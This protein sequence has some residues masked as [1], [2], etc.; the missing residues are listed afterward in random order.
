ML[1]RFREANGP[2]L[3]PAW[4]DGDGQPTWITI[5]APYV[6]AERGGDHVHLRLGP[7]ESMLR[8]KWARHC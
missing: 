2:R 8:A 1:A 3:D 7:R 4:E 5:P 6:R